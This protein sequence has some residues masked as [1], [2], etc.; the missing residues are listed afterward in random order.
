M[1]RY[2]RVGTKDDTLF[3][4]VWADNVN[5]A[6]RAVEAH[7]DMAMPPM[8][9]VANEVAREDV[10]EGDQVIGE[11]EMEKEVREDSYD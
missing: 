9:T 3:H 11:P 6:I 7:F 10:P 2:F 4:Y 5:H 1:S 8:R